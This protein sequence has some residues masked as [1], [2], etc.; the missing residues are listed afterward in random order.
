MLGM[1]AHAAV[2]LAIGSVAAQAATPGAAAGNRPQG[3]PGFYDPL[4][5]TF[6]PLPNARGSKTISGT[7]EVQTRDLEG[8]FGSLFCSLTFALGFAGKAQFFETQAIRANI[9][10]GPN[11]R[12][13]VK[14]PFTYLAVGK[15]KPEA[16][17][18]IGCNETDNSG[19]SYFSG[20]N[21][22]PRPL[23][24]HPPPVDITIYSGE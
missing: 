5:H 24:N 22:P 1:L 6:T 23:T 7:Q 16:Q 10:M 11:Q 20:V 2:A 9:S 12:R 4:T 8:P 17:L 21:L 3:I 14:I 18:S 15:A 13:I 19:R